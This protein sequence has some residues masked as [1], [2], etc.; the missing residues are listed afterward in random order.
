MSELL[1]S[2]GAARPQSVEQRLRIAGI[3]SGRGTVWNTL[4]AALALSLGSR[5]LLVTAAESAGRFAFALS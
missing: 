4:L 2:E 5:G 1:R 3:K